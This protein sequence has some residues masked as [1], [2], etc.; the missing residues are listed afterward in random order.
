MNREDVVS[1]RDLMEAAA[2]AALADAPGIGDRIGRITTVDSVNDDFPRPASALAVRLGL[3]AGCE[4]TTIGG[5]TPQWLVNRAAAD[6]AA[7]RLQATLLAGAE[8]L[9]SLKR[10]GVV[11]DP[12]V[13]QRKG[14]PDPKVGVDRLGLGPA[15]AGIGLMLPI[16][17]Y[18]MF[19]SAMAAEAGR[20]FEEQRHHV[21]QFMA[22]NSAVAARHPFAW[23]PETVPPEELAAVTERN[24]LTADPYTLRLNAI[25]AVDQGAAVVVCSLAVAEELGLDSQAVF[26]W[27]GA[28]TTE[29][30]CPSQRPELSR[31][32]A[33]S[34][35]GRAVLEAGG[36]GVDE[37][38]HFDLYS[39]FPSAVEAG[40]EA[41]G[42]SL[43]D[44]RG[45]TV[46]GGLAYFGGPGNNYSMHAI[47]TIAERLR[48][49][50][51]FGLCTALGWYT[52]KHSLGLYGSDPA[53]D[54][55]KL[56]DTRDAQTA[57]DAA[58]L[59]VSLDAEGPAT[60]VA[61][62]TTYDRDGS[63]SGTPVFADL[64]DGR[65]VAATA[66]DDLVPALAGRLLV[67]EQIT[68]VG[69]GPLTFRI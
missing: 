59:A 64:P 51:G 2:R 8:A 29:V 3:A 50:R 30:W 56:A 37:V 65:R 21:A 61:N 26:V 58:E 9:A 27:S 32:P 11:D 67:G 60:V 66:A 47:A 15:E 25:M 45:L 12:D 33:I 57:I 34:A 43:D 55:F 52:T 40:A 16:H 53:P 23:F 1:P 7:G 62:T 48:E 42:V 36:I 41:L 31:S 28:D 69:S 39:C 19:E 20:S 46:T 44:P 13:P 63:P 68:L 22:R 18:P 6:I 54:G 5:N 49:D 24:R 4:S 14:L 17:V 35:A 10:G 38:E